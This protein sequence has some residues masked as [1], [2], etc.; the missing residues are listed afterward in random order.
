MIK[1]YDFIIIGAGPAG[2]TAGIYASRAGLKTAMIESGAPGGKLLKTNEISNWPGIKTEPG[3]QLAM[4]MFEHSTSF[5]AVYEYG[6]VVEIKVDE[7]NPSSD[8]QIICEDGTV[9]QAP[10]VLVA[11]GTKERLMGIP[12]EKQNIGRG[13]S[14]CAVCDGAFFRDQEVAVIGGGNSALEEAVYLTHFASKVYILMRRNVFRADKIAVDA[15]KSNPKIEII[16]TVVPTEILDDGQH[17]NGLKITDVTTKEERTLPVSGIFPY[18]GADPVT[19]FLKHLDVLNPQGYMVVNASME[20]KIPL[21]YGAGDVCQKGLRQVV[22]AVNDGAV[23]AQDAF[24]K[25]NV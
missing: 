23:A 9:F 5:G 16:Q 4:D 11:T 24:H 22:T 12:G 1:K 13:L 15:A 14:Y 2:M 6:N 21:L 10:A 3:S 25:L 20:T 18:I 19:G 8:K 7:T 17:V